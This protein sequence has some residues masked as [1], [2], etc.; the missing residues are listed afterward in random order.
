[1]RT[2]EL[3]GPIDDQHQLQI[4]TPPSGR[5]SVFRTSLQEVWRRMSR[6]QG[7]TGRVTDGNQC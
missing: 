6:S 4:R 2:V 3:F 1:M 7:S 5:P